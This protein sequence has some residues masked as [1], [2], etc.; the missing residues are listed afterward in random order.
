MKNNFQ[1]LY[2]IS[3]SLTSH[4][5]LPFPCYGACTATK[6]E[7]STKQQC[8][9]SLTWPHNLQETVIKMCP[10][11]AVQHEIAMSGRVI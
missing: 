9:I 11:A 2:L 10:K 8:P 5:S 4:K 3:N 7:R 1:K 6:I